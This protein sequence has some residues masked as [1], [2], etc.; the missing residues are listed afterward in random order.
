MLYDDVPFKD[1]TTTGNTGE[2]MAAAG[3]E[4]LGNAA[5]GV[6]IMLGTEAGNSTLGGH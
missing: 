6:D 2:M 5:E 4:D 3:V 1:D